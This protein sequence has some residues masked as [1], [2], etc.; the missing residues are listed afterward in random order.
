M[1]VTPFQMESLTSFV[2]RAAAMKSMDTQ[3]Y[4]RQLFPQE[5]HQKSVQFPADLDALDQGDFLIALNAGSGRFSD[6]VE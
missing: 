2:R 1:S 5:L 4:L 6:R 3:T